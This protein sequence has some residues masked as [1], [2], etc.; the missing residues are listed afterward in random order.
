MKIKHLAL[1]VLAVSAFAAAAPSNAVTACVSNSTYGSPATDTPF[2]Y[3]G[4]AGSSTAD[5]SGSTACLGLYDVPPNDNVTDINIARFFGINT[6][7]FGGKAEENQYETGVLGLNAITFSNG[8]WSI[9]G[10]TGYANLMVVLKQGQYFGAY[11]VDPT[12]TSGSWSTSA[13][14]TQG[15]G[16]LSHFSVYVNECTDPNGCRPGTE[17]PEPA[18][19]ALLGLGLAGLG[20]VRRRRKV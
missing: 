12:V 1:A 3:F 11:L 5:L 8:T 10:A 18:T 17:V 20:L 13:W 16:G 14:T 15:A 7:Q 6:W 9:S 4:A 19:L 2:N